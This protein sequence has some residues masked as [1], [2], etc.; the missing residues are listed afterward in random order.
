[1]SIS[2][3]AAGTTSRQVVSLLPPNSVNRGSALYYHWEDLARNSTNLYAF[4]QSPAWW[5]YSLHGTLTDYVLRPHEGDRPVLV[6][7][8]AVDGSLVGAVGV[9][10]SRCPLALQFRSRALGR[11]HIRVIKVLG[12]QPLLRD[13]E[14]LYVE[15]IRT[16]FG[17]FPGYDCIY[18]RYVPVGSF[19]WNT[20]CGSRELRRHARLYLP[21]DPVQHLRITLPQS[22]KDYLQKFK[23]KTRY[24]LQ[25]QVRQLREHGG[26]QLELIRVEHS[27][28]V[29]RF[30]EEATTISAKSWQF[31]TLGLEMSNSPEECRK[32]I[33]FAD[34][35]VLRC[36]LLRCGGSPCTGIPVRQRLLLFADRLR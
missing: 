5:D 6:T 19:C 20:L 26:G 16:L 10:K 9:H 35:G 30:L 25:R 15:L 34:D 14:G 21:G 7:L 18:M 23:S 11:M 27:Q 17:A 36:Y 4:Y 1:V 24:N 31:K 3:D 32:F 28:D 33:Q 8:N 12:G 22:F 29:K 2:G 13:N